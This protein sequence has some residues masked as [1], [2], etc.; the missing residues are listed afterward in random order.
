VEEC[1]KGSWFYP[2]LHHQ[3]LNFNLMML[4]IDL[5]TARPKWQLDGPALLGHIHLSIMPMR[6]ATTIAK[7]DHWSVIL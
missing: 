1:L 7:A 5:L 4:S 3:I 2:V 6:I